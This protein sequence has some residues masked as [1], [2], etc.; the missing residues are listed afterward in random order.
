MGEQYLTLQELRFVREPYPMMVFAD[1]ARGL[2]SFAVK[3]RTKG[4]YGHYMWLINPDV[5]ASQWL[6]F[7]MFNLDHF[8]G[9]HLKFVY[10]STWSNTDKANIL[11]AIKSDLSLPWWRTLYDVPGVLFRLFGLRINIPWLQF[12]SERGEYLKI[13]DSEYDLKSP[14]P[15]ELNA[16]TKA[17]G[18]RYKV[19]AR[20]SP[21]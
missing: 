1:N 8:A 20:Y 2:F 21:D 18:D 3:T 16:W 17:R 15:S 4:Y 9:C 10:D 5:L 7:K 13:V 6:W 12:C 14:T 11:N 19:F